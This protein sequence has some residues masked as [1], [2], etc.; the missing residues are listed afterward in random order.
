[1]N[2]ILIGLFLL[3]ISIS[4]I[5]QD[6][7]KKK[8]NFRKQ[9]HASTKEQIYQLKN[10]ALLVRLKT[11]TTAIAALR[12]IGGNAKADIVQQQQAAFNSDIIWAFR[13]NFNFCP[14]YFF[15]SDYSDTVKAKHFD[16]VIFLNDSL[17]PD[18][19][20]KFD[21]KSFLI[22]DFGTVEQDTAKS[23]S[24]SSHEPDRDFSVKKVDHYNGGPSF[25]YDGLIIRSEQFIQLRHPFPYFVR[26]RDP[27]PTKKKL[28]KTV[29]AMN[30]KLIAFYNKNNTSKK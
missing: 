7:K 4:G 30:K 26:T 17:Q 20:I 1:M 12:K 13:K 8:P 22:A 15:Y 14:V 28:N 19:A 25:S 5:S 24:Y 21:G 18:P 6:T 27:R 29:K 23:Y 9:L 16:K 3:F 11:K 10:G 2:K